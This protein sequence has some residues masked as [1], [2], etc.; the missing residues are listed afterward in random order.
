MRRHARWWFP[1]A[2][3]VTACGESTPNSTP[4]VPAPAPGIRSVIIL[5]NGMT[6]AVGDSIQFHATTDDGTVTGF[7]WSVDRTDLA[8]VD[9]TGLVKGLKAGSVQVRA[10]GKPAG[11][12]CGSVTLTVQ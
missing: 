10:C 3:A 5:P 9:P 4:P 8:G 11:S 1:V 12:V 2:L 6:I 7:D